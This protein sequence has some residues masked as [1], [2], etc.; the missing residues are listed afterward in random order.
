MK[1]RTFVESNYRAM[2]T[3]GKTLRMPLDASLPITELEWPE[4][5]D[6]KITNKCFGGCSYCYQD[7]RA[8]FDH[9]TDVPDKIWEFFGNMTPNQRPFQVAIGGG[10]PT[11]H[12]DF[13]EICKTFMDLGIDPNYTTNG[14]NMTGDILDITDEFVTGVA[15]SCHEHLDWRRGV[16]RLLR[17][18][19]YTNLHVIISDEDSVQRFID[20]HEEYTGRIKY[21]VLLPMIAQGRAKSEFAVWDH[22]KDVLNSLEDR[23]D[24]AFGALF[25]PFLSDL[26]G[27]DISVYEPEAFSQYLVMDD[28]MKTYPSSFDTN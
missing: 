11:I 23:S 20:T 14:T 15:V 19:V 18:D 1:T 28:D 22:L 4:F 12:P 7:S 27:W 13:R 6:V 24:I 16:D 9:F 5:Y 17:E 8:G 10:E 3:G 26:E 2:Y 25:H 21:F